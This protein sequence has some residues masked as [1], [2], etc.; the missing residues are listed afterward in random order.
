MTELNVIS[1]CRVDV[2][3]NLDPF[4]EYRAEL[5]LMIYVMIKREPT[6]I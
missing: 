5:E 1:M 6:K 4:H 2:A 3:S